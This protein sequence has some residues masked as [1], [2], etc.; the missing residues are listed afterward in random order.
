MLYDEFD[1]WRVSPTTGVA[2]CVTDGLGRASKIRLRVEIL[3]REKDYL[4]ADL[5]LT[6]TNVETFVILRIGCS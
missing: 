2:T 5:L 4:P 6:A 1:L 3:D